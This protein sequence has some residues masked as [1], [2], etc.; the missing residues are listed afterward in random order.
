MLSDG[1]ATRCIRAE[2]PDMGVFQEYEEMLPLEPRS[3]TRRGGP[4]TWRADP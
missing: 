3:W 1:S 2:F 4:G